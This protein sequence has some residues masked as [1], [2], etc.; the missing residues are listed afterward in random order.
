MA[1]GDNLPGIASAPRSGDAEA[2]VGFGDKEDHPGAAVG[3]V[4]TGNFVSASPDE[5]GSG[6][7]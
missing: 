3:F 1:N 2:V 7:L 5:T 4:L 6:S